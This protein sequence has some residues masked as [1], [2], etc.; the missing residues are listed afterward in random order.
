MSGWSYSRGFVNSFI[1]NQCQ[2]Q[3]LPKSDQILLVY[4][5]SGHRSQKAAQKFVN[6]GYE[7]VYDFVVF[8]IGLM[9]LKNNV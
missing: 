4:C 7:H 2:N 8:L 3:Q 5:R 9:K 1:N 6:L